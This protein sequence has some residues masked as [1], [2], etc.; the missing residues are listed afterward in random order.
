MRSLYRETFKE[1]ENTLSLVQ[2]IQ[3]LD[4]TEIADDAERRVLCQQCPLTPQPFLSFL[5]KGGL[6]DVSCHLHPGDDQAGEKDKGNLTGTLEPLILNMLSVYTRTRNS[7]YDGRSMPS[8]SHRPLLILL[9]SLLEIL[10]YPEVVLGV[11]ASNNNVPL[12][13]DGRALPAERSISLYWEGRRIPTARMSRS[14]LLAALRDIFF[15]M[16]KSVIGDVLSQLEEPMVFSNRT[17]RPTL[18]PFPFGKQDPWYTDFQCLRHLYEKNWLLEDRVCPKVLVM[19]HEKALEP[20]IYWGIGFAHFLLW[21]YSVLAVAALLLLSSNTGVDETPDERRRRRFRQTLQ[22]PVLRR[23]IE[24]QALDYFNPSNEKKIDHFTSLLLELKSF[25]ER[26][27]NSNNQ[28]GSLL[29]KYEKVDPVIAIA[30]FMADLDARAALY[31]AEEADMQ[32]KRKESRLVAWKTKMVLLWRIRK[33]LAVG[34]I[35]S[36]ALLTVDKAEARTILESAMVVVAAF[37]L[38]YFIAPDS[39]QLQFK[40]KDATESNDLEE[41]LLPRP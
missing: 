26:R 8:D 39:P 9:D 25:T 37:G 18:P 19:A 30:G 3:L 10:E 22:D 2:D 14:D 16:D 40:K 6:L 28:S 15:K 29:D 13:F 17:L 36:F 31:Q 27:K 32:W 34:T 33:V 7:E 35:L 5:T 24:K 21:V 12:S 20:E 41:P 1:K 4:N 38:T 23:G 11:T